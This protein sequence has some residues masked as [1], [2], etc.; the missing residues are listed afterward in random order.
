MIRGKSA[1]RIRANSERKTQQH[2]DKIPPLRTP[3]R[4]FRQTSLSGAQRWITTNHHQETNGRILNAIV[5]LLRP[6]TTRLLHLRVLATC[7]SFAA[8]LPV[9]LP[10]TTDLVLEEMASTSQLVITRRPSRLQTITQVLEEPLPRTHVAEEPLS[11]T[12][13]AGPSLLTNAI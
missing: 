4:R 1:P 8:P 2:F 7:S 5:H 12:H 3:H 13:V 9:L 11:K 10:T 6:I